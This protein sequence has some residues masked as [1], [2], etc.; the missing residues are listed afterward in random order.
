[1]TR[2]FQDYLDRKPEALRFY[3]WDWGEEEAWSAAAGQTLEHEGP[4]E[5]GAALLGEANASWITPRAEERL[6]AVAA[7]RGVAVVGGQ[8]AGLLGGPLYTLHKALTLV[9]LADAVELMIGRPVLPVFWVASNDSDLE[10]AGHTAMVDPQHRLQTFQIHATPPM[11]SYQ[12]WPVG[13]IPLGETAELLRMWTRR[14]LPETD[15][16][17]GLLEE[18]DEAY[19]ADATV[20]SAFFQ[21][22]GSWLGPRGLVL[23]DPMDPGFGPLSRPLYR[24][25]FED[26][27]CAER[28]LEETGRE[29]KEAGY[30]RQL[31]MPSGRIPLFATGEDGVRRPILPAAGDGER[32]EVEGEGEVAVAELLDPDGPWALD[33]GAALRPLLQDHLLPVM[34]FVGGP[35]EIAYFGQ[36]GP[37][38]RD[39]EVPR[40][41]PLTRDRVILVPRT[42]ARV[43]E[44]Y[45]LA[46]IDFEEGPEHAARKVARDLFPEDLE[47]AFQHTE[48]AILEQVEHLKER[49]INFDP[50]LKA[51][52]E[53]S[54]GR[55]AGELEKLKE[56]AISNQSRQ[57]EIVQQQTERVATWLYPDDRPQERVLNPLPFA[58]RHGMEK[59]LDI[60]TEPPFEL[61]DRGVRILEL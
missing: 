61:K 37:L 49:V 7:G 23:L 2:L 9:R 8:Q 31:S 24:K 11:Q 54:G 30:H 41:V 46:V 19:H 42:A 45:S 60:L 35:A 20:G 4:R 27:G 53:T 25:V 44:K 12:G 21:L 13:R 48:E 57:Q 1:M 28:A 47:A 38:Y 52:F 14:H 55:M 51:P 36:L 56:K 32:V 15:F 39:L 26:P 33:P 58:V 18:V 22:M 10:E 17:E 34:G 5:A 43:L 50:T 29:L 40:P 3:G 16:R 6:E 59:L